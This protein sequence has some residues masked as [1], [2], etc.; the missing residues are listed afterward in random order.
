M[1]A[2]FSW[3]GPGTDPQYAILAIAVSYFAHALS[4]SLSL[5]CSRVLRGPRSRF[6]LHVSVL[7]GQAYVCRMAGVTPAIQLWPR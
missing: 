6:F 2:S 4:A 3:N 7:G 1:R 5:F